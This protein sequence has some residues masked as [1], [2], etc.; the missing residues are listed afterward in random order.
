LT[1]TGTADSSCTS[2][3]RTFSSQSDATDGVVFSARSLL[4][5]H[6]CLLC[7]DIR[8]HVN[9]DLEIRLRMKCIQALQQSHSGYTQFRNHPVWTLRAVE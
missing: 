9:N 8:S 5:V 4:Y 6:H 1:L 3:T 2:N 7:V